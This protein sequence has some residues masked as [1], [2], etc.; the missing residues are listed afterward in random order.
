ML[1]KHDRNQA[2]SSLKQ[3][4][5]FEDTG[6]TNMKKKSK[7]VP[8]LLTAGTAA[9]AVRVSA[10]ARMGQ[11]DQSEARFWREAIKA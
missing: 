8:Q 7:R 11:M 4:K 9:L 3:L 2:P 10:C 5:A 1:T 6:P